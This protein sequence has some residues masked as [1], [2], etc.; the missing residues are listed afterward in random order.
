MNVQEVLE[1]I[2][3]LP[4]EDPQAARQVVQALAAGGPAVVERLVAAVGEPGDPKGVKPRYALHA[5]ATWT[6]RPGAETERKMFAQALAEQLAKGLPV[7]AKAFLIEQLQWCGTAAEA[8]ELN[9]W[10][11][12]QRLGEP[13]RQALQAIGGQS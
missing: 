4:G 6:A 8:P 11:K 2:D 12:H 3:K 13:A 1:A 10:L 5:L 9:K 7:E